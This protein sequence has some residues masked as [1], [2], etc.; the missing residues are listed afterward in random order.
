MM[1]GRYSIR[2]GVG[3][4][5][6]KYAPNAPGAPTCNCVL[7]AEAIGGQPL[8][9]PTTAEELKQVGYRTGMIGKWHLGQRPE[10]MP[11]N[12]GF[13]MYYGLPAS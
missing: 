11:Y 6:C 12:R 2:N 9:I 10:Y 4:E 1:S 13:D 3:T 7:T 8:D 5:P